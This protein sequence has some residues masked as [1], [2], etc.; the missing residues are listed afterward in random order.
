MAMDADLRAMRSDALEIFQTGLRAV[1]PVNAVKR[2][3]KK[4]D[5]RI[6][7]KDVEYD[8]RDYEGVYLIGFGKAGASMGRA[9]EEVLGDTLKQGIVTVKYGH[10]DRVSPKIKIYEAGHPVPDKAG[11]DAAKEM[12]DFLSQ[13][14]AKDLVIA[15]ISGG[16]SALL[17]LPAE[18]IS[19]SE[20]QEMTRLLLA[21]GAD[22]KEINAIRKHISQVKGGQLARLAQPATLVTLILSDVIGDPLDSIASGPTAPDQSTF[23]DCWAILQKYNLHGKVP[24]AVERH[25]QNGLE[26]L[27]PDTPKSGDP[28]FSRTQ[29]V[30]V[31]SNWEAV[32]AARARAQQLG[33]HTLILSTFVE[34]ETKDVARVHAAIAKEVHKTGNPIKKPCCIISGGETTVT[35]HGNGLGGRNQEFVLAAA[36]DLAGMENT[37]VLS[38]G[39]D[40]SD[41]PTDAAGAIADGQTIARANQLQLKA[42]QFLQNNDSYHFFEP[43]GDLIKTGP[44][45]TNVMDIRILLMK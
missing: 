41:G 7:V 4:Q 27:L 19:L 11:L 23:S 35:I 44:T 5:H 26:G 37:V 38:A 15:V 21:C 33:Y 10:L 28:I 25:I 1:D 40:G 39:T 30:I 42:L 17:P 18:G 9:V 31:A 12:V 24:A 22:I 6:F 8:L 14:S 13:R 20:K 43:L 36:M 34:G 3:L 16:G 29:N 2:F 32:A 45:N